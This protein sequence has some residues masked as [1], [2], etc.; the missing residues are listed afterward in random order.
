VCWLCSSFI[1]LYI[2]FVFGKKINVLHSSVEKRQK[3]CVG[4]R[5]HRRAAMA[6]A[7]CMSL[8]QAVPVGGLCS[9]LLSVKDY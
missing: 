7:L 3:K 2:G 4:W 9:A 5:Q 1:F 8:L 6:L